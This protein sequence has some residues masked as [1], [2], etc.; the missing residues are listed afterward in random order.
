MPYIKI[1]MYG[2][3][4]GIKHF[5]PKMGLAPVVYNHVI[6]PSYLELKHAVPNSSLI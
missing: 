3:F 1:F 5:G 4:T 2:T 6:I